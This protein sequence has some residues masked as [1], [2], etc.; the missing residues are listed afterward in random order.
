MTVHDKYYRVDE[1]S[2]GKERS[3]GAVFVACPL[4]PED[5]PQASMPRRKSSRM[6]SRP[7]MRLSKRLAKSLGT[8]V[9]VALRRRQ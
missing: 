9:G 4:T 8:N 5:A 1:A 2:T 7:R 3:P 6:L